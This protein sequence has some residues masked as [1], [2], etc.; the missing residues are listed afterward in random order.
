MDFVVKGNNSAFQ[1]GIDVLNKLTEG[2]VKVILG[3]RLIEEDVGYEVDYE[4][5]IVT[6]IDKAIEKRGAK[7]FI[8][9]GSRSMGNHSDRA[10]VRKLLG[11]PAMVG[12]RADMENSIWTNASRTDDPKVWTMMQPIRSDSIMVWR[13]PDNRLSS[14]SRDLMLASKRRSSRSEI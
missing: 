2:E 14:H 3:D 12:T 4:Q 9:A 11:L 13:S 7:Y 5:G 8:S 6:I 10:L 1:T